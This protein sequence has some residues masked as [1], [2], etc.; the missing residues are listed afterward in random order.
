MRSF[1]FGDI[2]GCLNELRALLAKL[3]PSSDDRL[4]FLGDLVDKGPFG[5]EC[6]AFVRDLG[7]ECLLGN[8]E[9]SALRWIGHEEAR[10]L[11]VSARKHPKQN[12]MKSIPYKVHSEWSRLLPSDVIWLRERPLHVEI[13]PGLM[14]VHAGFLPEVALD[15]QPKSDMLR[16]RWVNEVGKMVSLEPDM[17]PWEVPP[18]SDCWMERW[19]GAFGVVYG[20]AVHSL[21]VPRIDVRSGGALSWCFGIDTG[22]VHGG[23]LTAMVIDHE[24]PEAPEFVQ[25]AAEKMYAPLASMKASKPPTGVGAASCEP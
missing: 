13:V 22:C 16:V 20:H 4:I 24:R 21:R 25:V 9:E 7:A 11:A 17:D 23:R 6:V 12:P 5:P 19:N 1:I 18:G 15:K 3:D 8:H 2:H 10:A 14:A